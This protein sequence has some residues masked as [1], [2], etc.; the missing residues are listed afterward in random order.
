MADWLK[1]A[2]FYE[3]YP[4]SF[5]DSNGDGI[6]DFKGIEEKLDY[7][8]SLG[9][10]AIWMNPCFDSP[11]QDAG[12]DVR[13]YYKAAPRYGTNED[14]QHLFEKVHERGMH[15][16][17]DLVPG[18]TSIEHP[19]FKESC[20][21]D[22]NEFT[23]RYIWRTV[24]MFIHPD[25]QNIC[26]FLTGIA[27]RE[28]S[29]AV[30]CFSFQPALNY[31]FGNVTED[32]MT[33]YGSPAADKGIEILEDIMSFWMDKGCDGFRVDMAGSLVKEDPDGKCVKDLWKR[34]RK[35]LDEKY[36]D[37]R[38]VSEW[39]YPREALNAGFHMDFLLHTGETHYMDLFRTNPY[40]S[41]SSTGSVKEFV[42]TYVGLQDS[43]QGTDG[44]ICIPSGNHDMI[45]MREYLSEEEMK[46]AFAFIYA[47]PGCPFLYY[48]DEIGIKYMHGLR[49]KE[50]GYER[51]GAR[52]PMQWTNGVNDGF[53]TGKA[54]DL[55]LPVDTEADATSVEKQEQDP[56]SLLST[57]K[58]LINFRN[59]HPALGNEG[60]VNFLQYGDHSQVLVLERQAEDETIAV[61]FNPANDA[62]VVDLS[63]WYSDAELIYSVQRK[64]VDQD[65][66]V[67]QNVV[68][69]PAGTAVFVKAVRR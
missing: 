54:E 38:L 58:N 52:T 15:I 50:G 8:Q 21:P 30:N 13:D 67:A 48:G 22:Q 25:Y 45:R 20:E 66:G 10:N 3:V 1:E 62:F 51:T 69:L 57:V 26:S 47:M 34:V 29:V 14:L 18:H 16:L 42:E 32:W 4:Q 39:G 7:I 64:D 24:S 6:G 40:F 55:Y 36:P 27:D 63:K 61:L 2:N 33:P 60:T 53:S 68:T 5:M 46:L 44:M 12:Y 59:A 31:G 23:D 28:G 65:A 43:I 49:S 35:F 41:A 11:F 9:C 37:A 19:W 56:T 17:L